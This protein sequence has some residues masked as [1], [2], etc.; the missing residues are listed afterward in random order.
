VVW[1]RITMVVGALGYAFLLDDPSEPTTQAVTGS[2]LLRRALRVALL[3]PSP[4]PGGPRPCGGS[5]L[6][7]PGCRSRSRR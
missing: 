6:S 1:L 3:L 2:L 4:P 5:G 7:T